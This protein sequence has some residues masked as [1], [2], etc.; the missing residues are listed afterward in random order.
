MKLYILDNEKNNII[1]NYIVFL[2]GWGKIL[3]LMSGNGIFPK[4]MCGYFQKYVCA[5]ELKNKYRE[6]SSYNKCYFR[7][8]ERY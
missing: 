7:M 8:P 6:K 1:K 2:K 4:S 3:Y 5:V